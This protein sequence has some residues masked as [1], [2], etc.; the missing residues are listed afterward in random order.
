MSDWINIMK[1]PKIHDG[2]RIRVSLDN[3]PEIK[4][5]VN[6]PTFPLTALRTNDMVWAYKRNHNNFNTREISD[7]S[8]A[9]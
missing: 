9:F 2:R 4:K 8:Y 5:E 7:D 1:R 3:Y 6:S